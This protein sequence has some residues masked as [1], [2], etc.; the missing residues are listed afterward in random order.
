MLSNRCR[1]LRCARILTM[2]CDLLKSWKWHR[3]STPQCYLVFTRRH[4]GTATLKW[5]SCD[6]TFG[7]HIRREILLSHVFLTQMWQRREL[8]LLRGWLFTLLTL[9]E[10]CGGRKRGSANTSIDES[11]PKSLPLSPESL[12]D[13]NTIRS[14]SFRT[15]TQR[16]KHN[17]R[18]QFSLSKAGLPHK[19]DRLDAGFPTATSSLGGTSLS[20]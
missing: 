4:S 18:K 19:Q 10:L 16:G 5:P 8:Y 7:F 2:V 13:D 3:V 14:Q 15:G 1:E 12:G 17:S 20:T 6:D 9:W 11:S